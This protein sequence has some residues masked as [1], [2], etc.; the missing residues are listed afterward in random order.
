MA[1]VPITIRIEH[2]TPKKA[3]LRALVEDAGWGQER[4]ARKLKALNLQLPNGSNKS[5][6]D[7]LASLK[8]GGPV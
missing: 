5:T 1:R 6:R 2:Q 4:A 8:K 7:G 3:R